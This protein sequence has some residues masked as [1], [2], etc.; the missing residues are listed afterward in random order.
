ML[1]LLGW[2]A[3]PSRL[4]EVQNFLAQLGSAG[5]G[6]DRLQLQTCT[7][8]FGPTSIHGNYQIL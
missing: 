8:P 2:D 5:L 6:K 4:V 1:D 7:F 3:V